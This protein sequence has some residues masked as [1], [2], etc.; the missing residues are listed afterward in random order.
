MYSRSSVRVRCF[1]FSFRI[2]DS[3]ACLPR[4]CSRAAIRSS[5]CWGRFGGLN[6]IV[7]SARLLLLNPHADQISTDIV[8]LRRR[9]K[10]FADEERLRGPSIELYALRAVLG[11][12]FCLRKSGMPVKP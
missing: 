10:R 9:V 1:E 12:G 11:H 5:Y 6:F 2:A 8:A 4:R 7:E 3:S